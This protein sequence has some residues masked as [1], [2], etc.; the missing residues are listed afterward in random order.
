MHRWDTLDNLTPGLCVAELGINTAAPQG[1]H[2][3]SKAGEVRG[4]QARKVFRYSGSCGGMAM[5]RWYLKDDRLLMEKGLCLFPRKALSSSIPSSPGCPSCLRRAEYPQTPSQE[6][7]TSAKTRLC[8]H[9]GKRKQWYPQ[10]AD[11]AWSWKSPP[12]CL[13]AGLKM[14]EG[15][16]TRRC[17]QLPIGQIQLQQDWGTP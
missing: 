3:H 16:D 8:K 12:T 2:I 6:G 4:L 10:S 14:W 5:G 1:L 9:S 17:L 13:R 15:A 11:S 7:S